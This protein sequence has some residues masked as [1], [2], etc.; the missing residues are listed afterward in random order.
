MRSRRGRGR[1]GVYCVER[2]MKTEEVNGGRSTMEKRTEERLSGILPGCSVG[3]K[4]DVCNCSNR[5]RR[6]MEAFLH[7]THHTHTHQT[8]LV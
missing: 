4:N 1:G 7:P 8:V 3:V 2:G 6:R 5:Q